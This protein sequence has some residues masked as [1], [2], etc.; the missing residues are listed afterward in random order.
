MPATVLVGDTLLMVATQAGNGTFTTPTN[1]T[2]YN[3]Y[4]SGTSL[5]TY[6]FTKTATGAEGGTSVTFASTVNDDFATTTYAIVGIVTIDAVSSSVNAS[7]SN[8]LCAT[9][10]PATTPGRFLISVYSAGFAAAAGTITVPATQTA[11]TNQKNGAINCITLSTGYEI[12]TSGAATGT[13]TATLASPSISIGLNIVVTGIGQT[14][15]VAAV[16]AVT[17]STIT[18]SLT[19]KAGV[20]PITG[21]TGYTANVGGAWAGPSGTSGFPINL[22]ATTLTDS[23]SNRPRINLKSDQTYSMTAGISTGNNG[24]WQVWGYTTTFGDGTYA[25]IDG[26]TTGASYV[27]LTVAN[28]GPSFAWIKFQNNGATGSANGVS[29]SSHG[30]FFYRCVFSNVRGAGLGPGAIS[31]P[32]AVVECE[33]FG[34]NQSNTANLGGF[35]SNTAHM[36]LTRCISHDNTGS[37]SNG[38]VLSGLNIGMT[39]VDCVADSNGK[40]GILGSNS[41]FIFVVNCSCYGNTGAGINIAAGVAQSAIF[42]NCILSQNGTFGIN[43][44]GGQS[45][46]VIQN[47][48]FF[49]NTSGQTN[50]LGNFTTLM[51]TVTLSGDPFT[52]AASGDFSLNSTAGAGAACRGAGIGTYP[53]TQGGYGSTLGYPDIGA[54]QHQDAGGVGGVI[55]VPNLEGT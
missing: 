17:T 13:R 52:A 39:L 42:Q 1:W 3:S 37:N 23:S 20:V 7:S 26:G 50:N 49:S 28:F 48:A 16:T 35:V 38:F 55:F 43:N 32:L 36:N 9:V 53:T 22:M 6:V 4:T 21:T 19:R 31:G 47:C 24:P 10:T 25:T 29:V 45:S 34:C 8:C 54:V 15:F 11:T 5:R 46:S 41:G 33:A 40:D 51:G 27:L 44:S 14:G 18:L 30:S 12:L 2:L